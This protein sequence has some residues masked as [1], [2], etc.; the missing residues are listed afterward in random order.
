MSESN[1]NKIL[2]RGKSN[3]N[4]DFSI[5]L[6]NQYINSD[7]SKSIDPST[8]SNVLF[9]GK[10]KEKI[11]IPNDETSNNINLATS[12]S[13]N[14]EKSS[15]S[16]KINN[17]ILLNSPSFSEHIFKE[18][19][20]KNDFISIENKGMNNLSLEKKEQSERVKV[21]GNNESSQNSKNM[22]EN[23][24]LITFDINENDFFHVKLK[25]YFSNKLK[26]IIVQIFLGLSLF[27]FIMSITDLVNKIKN[28]KKIKNENN[29][30]NKNFSCLMKNPFAYVF[31]LLLIIIV[32]CFFSINHFIFLIES[33]HIIIIVLILF[34]FIL[35]I[36]NFSLI[37]SNNINLFAII[38]NFILN[39]LLVS[40]NTIF[41]LI[42]MFDKQKKKNML[43]NIDEIMN[44]SLRNEKIKNEKM[45]KENNK[46][47]SI[48]P[49]MELVE[50]PGD[51][52][53]KHI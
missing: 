11:Q 26:K 10:T 28:N 42:S 16:N 21:I 37:F 52:R 12:N 31:E 49:M 51:G 30:T 4:N 25:R 9:R 7:N 35:G 40:V 20:K 18:T 38:N 23:N 53:T 33:S 48:K 22:K 24:D 3:S 41:L 13:K 19:K 34:I 45:P 46:I 2:S 47:F 39:L 15:K 29:N 14:K 1:P 32:I 8:N 43:H 5:K 36:V 50:D 6:K 27:L 17:E 44:F